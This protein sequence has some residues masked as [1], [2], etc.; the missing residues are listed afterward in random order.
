MGPARALHHFALAEALHDVVQLLVLRTTWVIPDQPDQIALASWKYPLPNDVFALRAAGYC[1]AMFGQVFV[2]RVCSRETPP[3]KPGKG[4]DRNLSS[5]CF[6]ST[7]ACR[8][9]GPSALD[10]SRPRLGAET[11]VLGSDHSLGRTARGSPL[12]MGGFLGS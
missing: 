6:T 9:F 4:S 10:A 7:S 1:R 8:L 11:E 2:R 5:T 12:Q 3:P